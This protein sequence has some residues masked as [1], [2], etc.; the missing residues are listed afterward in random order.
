MF[1]DKTCNIKSTTITYDTNWESVENTSAIYT[2]IWCDFYK[3]KRNKFRS[4]WFVVEW[5]HFDYTVVLEWDKSLVRIWQIIELIDPT[6]WSY[7]DFIIDDVLVFRN[8]YWTID[9]FE[10]KVSQKKK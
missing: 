6:L 4:D 3:D 9:N 1:I 2:L 5:K 8:N 7:W 10:L